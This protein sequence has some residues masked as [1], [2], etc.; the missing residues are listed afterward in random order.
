[1]LTRCLPS[2]RRH[3]VCLLIAALVPAA[4]GAQTTETGWIALFNGEDLKDWI[5]K[6]TGSA[7]GINLRDTFRV[8]NGIL[9][10]S[11][12]DWDVF[13]GEFGHLFYKSA[14]SHY[15]LHVEYRF[16]GSQLAQGPAWAIRNNGLMLHSQDP[17]TMTLDQEFPVSIEAQLLG[18]DGVNPR[19]TGNVCS[20]G[21]HYLFRGALFTPHC[22]NSSSATYAGDQWVSLDIEVRSDELIRHLV[23]GELVFE[24]SGPQLDPAEADAQ[25]LLAAGQGLALRGGFIAIQA[26]SHPTEFRKIELLPLDP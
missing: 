2:L 1:M 20:P 18:G 6:F 5:P 13:N 7:L 8:D 25:R 15:R 22:Q 3:L 19:P 9:R 16:V 12:E 14:F 24:Y 11:Y 4:S 21:T 10:V 23:N 17:A 26:E